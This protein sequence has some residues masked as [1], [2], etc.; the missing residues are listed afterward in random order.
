M[1]SQNASDLAFGVSKYTHSSCFM[2]NKISDEP[3]IRSAIGNTL[4]RLTF[5]YRLSDIIANWGEP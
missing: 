5:S 3:I 2:A 1:H 4:Y